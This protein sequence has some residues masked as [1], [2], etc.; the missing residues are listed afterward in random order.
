VIRETENLMSLTANFLR[1]THYISR[2]TFHISRF[3]PTIF[4]TLTLTSC[5]ILGSSR[6]EDLFIPPSPDAPV[7]TLQ[8]GATIA[9]TDTIPS[10]PTSTAPSCIDSLTFLADLTLPDGSM[11]SPNTS[12]DKQWQVENSGTC[13]WDERYRLKLVSGPELSGRSEQALF[14]ARS[15][16]QATIRVQFTAPSEPGAYRSAWQAHS[17]QGE[18][19]GDPFFIDIVVQSGT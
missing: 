4:L 7:P 8:P 3:T 15:G 9:A 12:L 1:I 11:V 17:P 16:T 18:P 14:P 10:L 19:F 5:S 13:N 6:R 2:I